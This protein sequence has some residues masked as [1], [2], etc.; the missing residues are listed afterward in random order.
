MRSPGHVI[1]DAVAVAVPAPQAATLL[2]PHGR[3]FRHLAEVRMTPVLGRPV[4]VRHAARPRRGRA[5]L[6]ARSHRLGLLRQ[7]QA[8]AI[9]GSRKA[10]SC[11]RAPPGRASISNSIRHDAAQRLLHAFGHCRR[12][13]TAGPVVPC[14]ASL[15][16]RARRATARPAV[17][18]RRRDGRRRVRRL[19]HRA[20]CRGRVRKRPQ[21]CS[22]LLSTVGLA[23]ADRAALTPPTG[24]Q[25][26]AVRRESLETR[27]QTQA[28]SAP[29]RF[30]R[31]RG[32]S[33]P[34]R[35]VA[36]VARPATTAAASTRARPDPPARDSARRPGCSPGTRRGTADRRRLRTSGN[37]RY[38]TDETSPIS[39]MPTSSCSAVIAGVG[40]FTFQPPSRTGFRA[41]TIEQHVARILGET[42][43]AE[44]TQPR[45][46][47]AEHRF[48]CFGRYD[49]RDI[50]QQAE[51]ERIRQVREQHRG[52]DF[53]RRETRGRVHAVAQGAA[54][55]HGLADRMTRAETRST[56]S[57]PASHGR[58][59]ASHNARRR[60]RSPRASRTHPSRRMRRPSACHADTATHLL[61]HVG[62]TDALESAPQHP[63]GDRGQQHAHGDADARL[64]ATATGSA[65]GVQRTLSEIRCPQ[66]K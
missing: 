20:A 3:A 9:R 64:Q 59:S 47:D 45:A 41:C 28:R 53:G 2:G 5:P 10:G 21:P 51:R 30:R 27:P 22:L 49:Q 14:C 50:E 66:S 26:H 17:P 29:V 43:A 35:A 6:D 4:Y 1:F 31:W 32:T 54:T 15:A 60:F 65:S 25:Q 52:A 23:A 63:C 62:E 11:T 58:C 38:N 8:R 13:A 40:R 55:Q 57:S 36:R 34:P 48:E 42:E 18:R 46:G 16:S 39:T 7:Q 61:Q 12:T 19:V 24:A 33:A 44:R 56:P 37:S